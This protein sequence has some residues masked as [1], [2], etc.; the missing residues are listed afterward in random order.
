[1]PYSEALRL[2]IQ[3]IL[4]SKLRSFFTLLGI[5]VSE[6]WPRGPVPTDGA[7]GDKVLPSREVT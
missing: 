5:I 1:M 3:S 4:Q 2:A 6:F 7:G